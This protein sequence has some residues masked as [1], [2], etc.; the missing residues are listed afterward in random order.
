MLRSRGAGIELAT[1]RLRGGRT[2]EM[3][4]V[5]SE[6]EERVG[7]RRHGVG[8]FVF[9]LRCGDARCIDG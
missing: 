6:R 1:T 5:D 8:D 2:W 7:T 3:R 9:R 4:A